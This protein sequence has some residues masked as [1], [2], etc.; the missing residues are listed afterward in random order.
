VVDGLRDST[1][2]ITGGTGFLGSWI[3][4]TLRM[5]NRVK[6]TNTT[7]H[8]TSRSIGA[9]QK[10][11]PEWAKDSDIHLHEMDLSTSPKW[12]IKHADYIIHGATDVTKPA[13]T[14]I[15]LALDITAGTKSIIELIAMCKPKKILYMSSG[16]VNSPE[17][18]EILIKE[19]A[20]LF[21]STSDQSGYSSGKQISESLL[22]LAAQEYG[23]T[24]VITR[25]F[26]FLGP[27]MPLQ[28]FAIGNFILNASKG[29]P[30]EIKS[31]GL[32]IRSFLYSADAAAW[33]LTMLIKGFGT[34]NVG[35]NDSKS[36]MQH[37]TMVSQIAGTDSPRINPIHAMINGN[38]YAPIIHR[39]F[40]ELGL[41]VF[42]EIGD[43]IQRTL[44]WVCTKRL[45]QKIMQ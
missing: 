30:P 26:S 33:Y 5:L 31:N 16:A 10:N 28:K 11:Y 42:T 4:D 17:P 15:R 3:V 1:V 45:Q 19:N 32:A 25:G 24:S 39:A 36:L 35:S 7:I 41:C 9:A 34:Y 29:H 12:N 44:E 37:A 40:T 23:H 22:N 14:E 38:H 13:S 43:A 6:A 8:I 27:R 20:Q 18:G 2:V 21:L